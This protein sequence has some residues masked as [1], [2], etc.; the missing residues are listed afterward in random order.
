MRRRG[1]LGLSLLPLSAWA[2]KVEYPAVRPRPLL[3][4]RH[5]VTEVWNEG[6]EE[7]S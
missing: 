6:L 4:P 5:G 3:F 1:F 7:A 2:A